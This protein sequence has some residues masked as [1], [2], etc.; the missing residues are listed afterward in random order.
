MM[1][2]LSSCVPI[3]KSYSKPNLPNL[4]I[5]GRRLG[6][7]PFYC[8]AASIG[9]TVSDSIGANLLDTGFIV[10]ERTYLTNILEEQGLVLSGAT[11]TVDYGKIGKLSNVDYLLVG[12]VTAE[13]REKYSRFGGGRYIDVLDATARIVNVAT[14]EIILHVTWIRGRKILPGVKIGEY[15]AAGIKKEL[16]GER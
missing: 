1:S 3:T 2:L 12:T 5:E 16:R 10:I 6:I 13:Q 11:E 7:L 4:N 9:N 8:E 15:L 14:G